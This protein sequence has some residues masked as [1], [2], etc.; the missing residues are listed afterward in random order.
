[1]NYGLLRLEDMR[2]VCGLDEDYRF[3]CADG[4]ICLKLYEKGK[5]LIPL[6]QSLVIHNN[7]LDTQKK[8]NMNDSERDIKLYQDKWKHFVSTKIPEPRRMYLEESNSDV[9]NLANTD[10]S[11]NRV[12]AR[13]R[14]TLGLVQIP[15][16]SCDRKVFWLTGSRY[17][18]ILGV[19]NE[20]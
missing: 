7:V 15:L 20:T 8:S 16:I 9:L 11:S 14:I 2:G 18:Y 13:R 3:Y 1:M 17:G 4:D 19:V 10:M 5:M 12:K 6:P